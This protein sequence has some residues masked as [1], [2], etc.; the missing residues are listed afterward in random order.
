M[1]Q[2]SYAAAPCDMAQS[3]QNVQAAEKKRQQEG[4]DTRFTDIVKMNDLQRACLNNFPQYPTSL[5]STGVLNAAFDTIKKQ[6][7]QSINSGA[8][9]AQS[10]AIDPNI[11]QQLSSQVAADVAAQVTSQ[12]MSTALLD[13]LKRMFQ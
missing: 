1:C 8:S 4:V 13:S 11:V 9:Q 7:C 3:M 12:S 2:P 10:A 5:G 6:A